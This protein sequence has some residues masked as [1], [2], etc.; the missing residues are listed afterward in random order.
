MVPKRAKAPRKSPGL[1]KTKPVLPPQQQT[2]QEKPG[3]AE[4]VFCTSFHT[5]LLFTPCCFLSTPRPPTALS[6]QL[7]D[8]LP[9]RQLRFTCYS[10]RV[11]AL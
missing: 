4:G 3:N 7:S 9:S 2:L 6:Q 8:A 5:T 10:S 1:S 11:L